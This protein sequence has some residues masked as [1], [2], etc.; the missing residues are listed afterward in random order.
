MTPL[1]QKIES[2][3]FYKN[4]PVS[5]S[6]LSKHTNEDEEALRQSVSDMSSFYVDRGITLIISAQEIS[7]LTSNA[8]TEIISKLKKN[9]EEK[10]LSKQALETIAIIAYKGR[11]TKSEI[12]YIRGVNSIFI[13]RNLL[14]RGLVTKQPSLANKRSPFYVLTHDTFSFMGITRASELPDFQKITEKLV[15]LEDAYLHEKDQ[16]AR[17]TFVVESDQK[18]S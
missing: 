13:L 16:E 9:N 1:Q 5:Y 6:W 3:L 11:I 2:L 18:Q 17:Q 12:D 8:G 15:E 10:E 4:E 7:L 14:I